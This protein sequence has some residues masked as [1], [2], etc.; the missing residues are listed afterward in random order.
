MFQR[1]L[2]SVLLLLIC[3]VSGAAHIQN[4]DGFTAFFADFQKAVKAGDKDKV[5]STVKF[6]H[7]DWE[8][9]DALRKVKT[10]EAF[11]KN[12]DRMFTPVI[13][14]KIASGKPIKTDEGYFIMWNT[15]ELEYS[16]YFFREKDG[17][18]SF[19]GLTIGPR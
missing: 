15:K 3:G 14:S 13:K 1:T 4:N 11:L 12:Y 16:L 18:Y 5:A 6:D 2:R 19:L 8:A 17:S 7:F 10:K 9:S